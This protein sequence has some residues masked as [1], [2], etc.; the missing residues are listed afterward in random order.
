M[1]YTDDPDGSVDGELSNE[2]ANQH[3]YDQLESIY[4]A[5]KGGGDDGGGGGGGCNP[6]SPK[7]NPGSAPLGHAQW[8]AWCLD[9]VV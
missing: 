6:R 9:M 5:K 1:D 7:C 3:D 2:H 8:G 4:S